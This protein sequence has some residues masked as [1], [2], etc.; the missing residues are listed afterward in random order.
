M[1]TSGQ[2]RIAAYLTD[3]DVICTDCTE[4]EIGDFDLVLD[5]RLEGAEATKGEVLTYDERRDIEE[6]VE[7]TRDERLESEGLLPLIQ[8][9][10]DSDETW[11]EHGLSCGRCHK[12]LVEPMPVEE[13]TDEDEPFDTSEIEERDQS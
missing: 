13:A 6:E 7:Q 1:L 10:L 11:Q 2:C 3:G 9:D 8:Y 4:K 12:E 5:E